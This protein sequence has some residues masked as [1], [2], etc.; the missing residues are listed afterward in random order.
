M[1]GIN[2]PPNFED[3]SMI[4]DEVMIENAVRANGILEAEQKEVFDTE[5]ERGI[6]FDKNRQRL[7]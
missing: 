6:I 7:T 1:T 2:Q 3:I 5:T 4:I